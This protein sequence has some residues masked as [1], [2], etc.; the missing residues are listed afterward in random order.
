VWRSIGLAGLLLSVLQGFVLYFDA[1]ISKVLVPEWADG[2][3]TYYWMRDLTFSPG[4]FRG[5]LVR[6]LTGSRLGVTLVTWGTLALEFALAAALVASLRYRR[7]IFFIG[8]LFHM[9]IAAT[10][11]LVTF[12]F[13]AA[14][15]LTL[16]LHYDKQGDAADVFYSLKRWMRRL[17]ATGR[18]LR[19]SNAEQSGHL[20]Q[21][22]RSGAATP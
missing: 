5:D 15:Q 19:E 2:T 4:G 8:L 18:R 11:G 9:T 16:Y 12:M 6:W 22:N 7:A 13:S 14:G 3:A 10:Y 17:I 1:A 20:G 21:P